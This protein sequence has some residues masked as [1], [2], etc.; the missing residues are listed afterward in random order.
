V[1][2]VSDPE[3]IVNQII[4]RY[5]LRW[6]CSAYCKHRSK[7]L[8]P[9]LCKIHVTATAVKSMIW[10][11]LIELLL[12]KEKLWCEENV[13]REIALNRSIEQQHKSD[14]LVL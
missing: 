10:L 3:V 7:T 9:L 1:I 5:L 12:K 11:K 6:N 4:C 14:Q 13:S 2:F 8:G